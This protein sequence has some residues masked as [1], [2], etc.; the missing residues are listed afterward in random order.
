MSERLERGDV[1]PWTRAHRAGEENAERGEAEAALAV[2]G[3][4]ASVEDADAALGV[5]CEVAVWYFRR[6]GGGAMVKGFVWRTYT[7]S[8]STR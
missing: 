8:R 7:T 6:G 5:F 2:L 3:G 4:L 1:S